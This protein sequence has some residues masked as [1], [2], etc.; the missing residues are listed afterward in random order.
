LQVACQVDGILVSHLLVEAA[1]C[2]DR[3]VWLPPHHGTLWSARQMRLAA[4]A[5]VQGRPAVLP[6]H[7]DKSVAWTNVR[8]ADVRAGI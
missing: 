4:V 5:L 7:G 3:G 2:A 8:V 6:A 1:L